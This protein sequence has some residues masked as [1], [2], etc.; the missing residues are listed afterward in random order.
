[1]KSLLIIS[2]LIC[3]FNLFSQVTLSK[4]TEFMKKRCL[5][6]DMEYVDGR[7][8]KYDEETTLFVFLTKKNENYCV[9]MISQYALEVMSSKCGDANKKTEYYNLFNN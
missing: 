8:Y 6:I 4:A 1:M 5:D 9:S 3:S 7:S 2:M